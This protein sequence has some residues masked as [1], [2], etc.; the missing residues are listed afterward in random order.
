MFMRCGLF[1]SASLAH[2]CSVSL[3]FFQAEVLAGLLKMVFLNAGFGRW[4]GGPQYHQIALVLLP[5]HW[6]GRWHVLVSR[7]DWHWRP[8][9]FENEVRICISSNTHGI[10]IFE[11]RKS[12]LHHVLDVAGNL[13]ISQKLS[14]GWPAQVVFVDGLL[15]WKELS[16]VL[17]WY[18]MGILCVLISNDGNNIM[19]SSCSQ[20]ASSAFTLSKRVAHR[21]ICE[22]LETVFWSFL[23][24]LSK[25]VVLLPRFFLDV[26]HKSIDVL[27]LGVWILWTTSGVEI[28]AFPWCWDS[29]V[30]L[31]T[32]STLTEDGEWRQGR[33]QPCSLTNGLQVF[34]FLS[35]KIKRIVRCI[36]A[37]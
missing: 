3:G 1:N 11:G 36:H 2:W 14:L 34:L 26:V 21:K 17:N 9:S 35:N 19:L 28:H 16:R 10:A 12:V 5:H 6:S 15:F 33:S 30:R 13:L 31:G 24:E 32:I 22:S 20:H 7:T 29:G 37:W 8:G 27:V 23:E 25:K 4:W 18:L